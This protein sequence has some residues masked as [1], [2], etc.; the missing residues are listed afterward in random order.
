MKNKRL[1]A[2]AVSAVMALNLVPWTVVR[3]DES[4]SISTVNDLKNFTE[5]CVYDE[6]SKNKS[7]VLQNDI[8]LEGTE[9]KSAEIFCGTFEGGGH[10]IKNF[11]LSAEGS[12][13]GLF[14]VVTKDAQIKDLN[15]T[16]E[17][18]ITEEVNTESIIRK[19]ASSILSRANITTEDS[20]QS[21]DTKSAGG[22]AGYNAGK[23]VNC[24]FGGK[25]TG[26]S[27]VGGIAG[28]NTMTGVIDSCANQSEVAGD[29]EIGGIAGYNEGRIKLSKNLGKICPEADENTVN[30]GGIAGNSE[31]ALVICTN[32]GQIGGESFGDN[33][34]GISGKQ[35]GEI[36]ECINNG[37]VQGRRSVGGIC[38]RFEPYTDIELSYDAARAAIEKQLDIFR[39]DTDSARSK[40]I[41]YVDELLDGKGTISEILDRLGLGNGGTSRLDRL[42][43]SAVNMMDS[44]TD[45]VNSGS[46]KETLDSLN[47]LSKDARSSIVDVSNSLDNTLTSLDNFLDEFDGK[48]QEITD[49]LNNLNDALDKGSDDV[50]EIKDR[51]F[52]QTDNLSEDIDELSKK[53]DST[54]NTL[55]TALRQFSTASGEATDLIE[56]LDTSVTNTQNELNKIK[57]AV[58]NVTA[59]IK[60][61]R[62]RIETRPTIAPVLPTL[63]PFELNDSGY[64]VEEGGTLDSDYEVEPSVVGAVKEFLVPSAHAADEKKTA[65]S[66]LESTDITL[67]R[68]IGGENADTALIK[69]SVNNGT[70]NGNEMSG[71]IAGSIG[72]ESVIRSGENLTLPDGTKVNADSVLKAVVDGC[73]SYGAVTAKA[74]YAGGAAGKCDIGNIKNTLTTGEIEVTDGSYAGGIAG[75]CSGDIKN[76]I[77]VNDIDGKSYIGGIAGSGKTIETSYS[78]AR[79]DGTK[80]KS[81]AIAG[82]VS[83]EV[84]GTYFI[85][86]GLSGINGANLEGRADAVAPED[87]AV[88]DGKIPAKMPAL[89]EEDFYMASDDLFMPQIKTLAKND[90]ENIGAILQSKSTEMSRFH[91]NV[92]FVDKNKEL[93][94]MTMDYGTVIPEKDI[95]RLTAEGK[96]V[97]MWDKDTHAPIVRHTKFTAVYNR[98]ATTI[99]SNEEPPV[100]LVESVFEDGTEVML[101]NEDVDHEF[102]GYKKGEAYSFTL[103]K[104]AYDT[105]KVHIRTDKKNADKI[106]VQ[107]NGKWTVLDC[108]T[109]GSYA[110]FTVG[111][112][113]KFVILYGKTSPLAAALMAAGILALCAAGFAVFMFIR[114]KRNGR[115]ETKDI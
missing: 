56:D 114:R 85:D 38:G 115:E 45:S 113:C 57:N 48:G 11:K 81:G 26:Q 32:E 71:G 53:L 95:P 61:L 29:T 39:D 88:S 13:K 112:P 30:I 12:N 96:E 79:L 27:E 15:V 69:Y 101:R 14:A 41:D 91:F 80:D 47:S 37:A 100:L 36:R 107:E 34:G 70:V 83:A 8:D 92:V 44:I 102:G 24:S 16:G 67:P 18:K 99:S 84:E 35:S 66:D 86:E 64:S 89:S 77:A 58:N 43:D 73:I 106:A 52:E 40:I 74:N 46:L 63:P 59:P 105:I 20:T 94:S 22:I 72:F 42:N 103:S 2:F 62:E 76:C 97:P 28:T 50:D 109:D 82:F 7:F 75:M 10:S 17:I 87:I 9:I 23:I 55:R 21:S 108:E 98:A 65:I 90:A 6:Y 25:I 4:V 33:V 54:H 111:A 3:A 110:V 68:L 49:T 19:R 93:R 104:N 51:L 5:K 60:N 31:G 1:T 78:L